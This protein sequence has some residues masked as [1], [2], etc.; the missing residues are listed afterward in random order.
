MPFDRHRPW[1]AANL[2]EA[3]PAPGLRGL[4]LALPTATPARVRAAFPTRWAGDAGADTDSPPP[5]SPT[6]APRRERRAAERAEG[7]KRKR[8]KQ[9]GA[10]GAAMRWEDPDRTEDHY[11]QGA[12]EC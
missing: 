12:C 11:P 8:G 3:Q 2:S 6:R 7:K 4:C 10:P 5:A 9:P 1:P